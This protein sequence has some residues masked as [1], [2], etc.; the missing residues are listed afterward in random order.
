MARMAVHGREVTNTP[1]LTNG[2]IP[3]VLSFSAAA[4]NSAYVLGGAVTPAS[5]KSMPICTSGSW[6]EAASC[7]A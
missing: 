2:V 4:G 1:P 5:A 6:P 7:L 3:A